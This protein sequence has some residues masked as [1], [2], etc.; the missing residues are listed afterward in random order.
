MN[1]ARSR[2]GRLGLSLAIAACAMPV[3]QASAAVVTRPKMEPP[4]AGIFS[5]SPTFRVGHRVIKRCGLRPVLLR[6]A[7]PIP[8]IFPALRTPIP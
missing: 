7:S 1:G 2:L 8:L 6:S 4:C 5:Q 3:T